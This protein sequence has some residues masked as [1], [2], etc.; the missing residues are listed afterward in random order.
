MNELREKGDLYEKDDAVWFRSSQ[1]G[2]EKD[3]VIR[4]AD[5]A[6]TYFAS[7]V[8][9]HYMK[10]LRGFDILIDIWGADHHGYI[11]RVAA[12]LSAMGYPGALEVVLGQLVNLFRNGKP[13]RMSKRTGEMVTFE[14]LIDEVGIDAT[15]Y[16]ML[17]RSTEQ[18][19]DFD[20]EEA[21]KQDASNP[22]YYDQYAHARIC[23]MLRD[24]S[25]HSDE[26]NLDMDAIAS[27][28]IPEDV[29]LSLL[30][31]PSEFALM[32]KMGEFG[33]LIALAA[34]DRAPF[35]LTHY[36][37]ELASLFHQFYTNCP[38]L[39]ADTV[40]LKQARLALCDAT[41]IVMATTLGILG[42]SAPQRM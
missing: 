15:R 20:I 41:R 23:K 39:K 26:D 24:E 9:Y 40:E 29:D 19:I 3:R 30:T 8:A 17:S 31:D 21:K 16:Y 28:C 12:V 27:E 18:P 4:K 36:A 34:R 37:Q 38:V 35:R 11:A 32:R 1:Y 7:D 25:G 13:V 22:V 5:G 2:D 10:K 42:I 33:D 6:Y 14:E